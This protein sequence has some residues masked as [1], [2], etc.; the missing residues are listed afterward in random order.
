MQKR[1]TQ[2]MK[3][4]SSEKPHMCDKVS[5]DVRICQHLKCL[6][7]FSGKP[8]TH[9][10]I[11]AYTYKKRPRVR[12]SETLFNCQIEKS[13]PIF[14]RLLRNVTS[15][16]TCCLVTVFSQ[17]GKSFKKRY[18]FKMHLLTHIQSLG[19]SR[20]LLS[21]VVSA[22]VTQLTDE[23]LISMLFFY[24]HTHQVQV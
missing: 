15:C 19:D 17:C 7:L 3:T 1:L 24:F 14:V 11:T 12:T 10:Y 2:H 5:D 9:F 6:Q 4:H 18:T 16:I 22:L 13:L 21:T 23:F 20:S 8:V